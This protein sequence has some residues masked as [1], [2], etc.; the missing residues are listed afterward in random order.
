MKMWHVI[1]ILVAIV[2]LIFYLLPKATGK[3]VV[4]ETP[5]PKEAEVKATVLVTE[6]E[7]LYASQKVRHIL[8]PL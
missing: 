8:T 4:A 3:T 2:L 1:I 5:I 6:A 7:R